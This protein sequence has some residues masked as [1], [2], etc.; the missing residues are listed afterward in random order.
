M[1]VMQERKKVQKQNFDNS[2]Y[3]PGAPKWKI[4]LWYFVNVIFFNSHL[5]PVVG[6]KVYLL[7]LFGAKVGKRFAIKPGVYIRFPWHFEAGDY[8][9]IG[10][11]V[12]IDNREKVILHNQT[13][14]SQG[15][16]ILPGYH[17]YK[18]SSFG[19]VLMPV[20]IE[21]GVWIASRA[22]VCGGVTCGSHSFLT[23]GSVATRNLEPY[24]IYTG[25]PAKPVRERVIED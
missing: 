4:I 17:D 7:K 8:V 18:K 10:E 22:I 25:N 12:F 16:M 20:I 5:F 24:T 23:A 2:W 19:I 6:P 1:N 9:S 13:T 14:V 15:A 21:E 11:N 3:K